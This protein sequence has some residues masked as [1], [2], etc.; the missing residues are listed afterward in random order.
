M[1]RLKHPPFQFFL[2]PAGLVLAT[3]GLA[4]SIEL[5]DTQVHAQ[6]E[7]QGQNKDQTADGCPPQPGTA[8]ITQPSLAELARKQRAE[9]AKES[10]PRPTTFT[11]DN[12]PRNSGGLSVV[13]PPPG[14]ENTRAS[15]GEG[16]SSAA[17]LRRRVAD[18]QQQLDTH[19]RELNV[20]QQKL[21]QSRLQYYPNPNDTLHQEYSREDIDRLTLAINQKK[22]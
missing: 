21:G 12:L 6:S 17:G 18:L 9:R 10:N 5:T 13:G 15:T 1:Q 8:I 11:N 19:Q 22:L 14:E 3:L 4:R 7:C 16:N 2:F 20:L